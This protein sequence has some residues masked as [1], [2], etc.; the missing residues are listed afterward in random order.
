MMERTI[1]V[2]DRT[3]LLDGLGCLQNFQDWRP[4][5]AEAMA[6]EVGITLPFSDNHYKVIAYLRDAFEKTGRTPIIH[7]TCRDNDIK[8]WQMEKLFPSGYHRGACKLAGLNFEDRAGATGPEPDK[9]Y[10]INGRGY[11]ADPETWDESF[12]SMRAEELGIT[13]TQ[14]HWKVIRFLRSEYASKG[15]V[16]TV[17]QVCR[18]CKLNDSEFELLFPRGYHRSA[19]KI[20]GL[21]LTPG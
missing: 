21:S 16:P 12:A 8:I 20:A 19:V 14:D 7:R 3:F 5:F 18:S 1:T 11:L 13:L 6:E 2:G 10:S 4:E 9:V 15:R 17:F